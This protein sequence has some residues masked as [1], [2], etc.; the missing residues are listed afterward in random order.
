MSVTISQ[1]NL[2][3]AMIDAKKN[4]AELSDAAGLSKTTI[5]AVRKGGRCSVTSLGKLA[6]ALNVVPEALI[7]KNKKQEEK[8][9]SLL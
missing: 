6:K 9:E 4:C 8:N 3:N 5:T 1:K 7:E 2:S